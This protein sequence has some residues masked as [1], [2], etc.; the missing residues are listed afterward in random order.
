ME[1]NITVENNQNNEQITDIKDEQ[2]LKSLGG[3]HS[4][5]ELQKIAEDGIIEF[6]LNRNGVIEYDEF[7]NLIIFLVNEKGLYLYE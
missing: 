2:K 6:D 7:Q 1:I 4:D 3:D 5:E